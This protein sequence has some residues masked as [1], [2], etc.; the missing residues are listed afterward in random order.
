MTSEVV[1]HQ[2]VAHSA[3]EMSRGTIE[4]LHFG[5]EV[6]LMR[7]LKAAG[8][9]VVVACVC[10]CIPGAHFV[11][12]PT[13][14][15]LSPFIIYRVHKQT[16]KIVTATI[17]CPKC[18]KQLGVLSS[19]EKYPLFENCASCHREVRIDAA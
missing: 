5:E 10:L 11:L 16:T 13:T 15:L 18:H 17:E 19:Q 1:T 14:V 6:R 7:S 4:A 12:V 8:I 9:C 3:G 2:I